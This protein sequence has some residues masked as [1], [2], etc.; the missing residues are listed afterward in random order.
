MKIKKF[1]LEKKLH[2]LNHDEWESL[3][4]NCGKCCVIKLQNEENNE[5]FYTNVSCK[6]LNTE[7]CKCTNYENRKKFVPDCVKL[8]PNNLTQL[9]WM[10]ATC[11]YKLVNEGKD[12]PNWHPLNQSSGS[13]TISEKYSVAKKVFSENEINMD[14]ITDYIY[15]WDNEVNNE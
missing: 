12:L 15:D 11:A 9:N 1:W 13:S 7:N 3:C 2:D 4:D 14:K 6:L 5:L 10:P 8:T